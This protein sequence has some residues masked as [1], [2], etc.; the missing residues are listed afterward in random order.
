VSVALSRGAATVNSQG[1]KPLGPGPIDE[2][3]SREAATVVA[4]DAI[5]ANR[6][7][8]TLPRCSLVRI[9]VTRVAAVFL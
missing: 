1:C 9:G 7:S 8:H 6:G 3:P 2:F 4:R 5:R